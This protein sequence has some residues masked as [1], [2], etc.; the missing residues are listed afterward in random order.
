MSAG[1]A[2]KW[3]LLSVGCAECGDRPLV[4]PMGMYDD[5]LAAQ[6]AA[7]ESRQPWTE[8]PRGG[9]IRQHSDGADWAAPVETLGL[10]GDGA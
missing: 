1:L 3:F 10:I 4:L 9:F 2:G 6:A 5:G 7:G 8:H